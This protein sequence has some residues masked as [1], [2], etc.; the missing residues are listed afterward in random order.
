MAPTAR[1]AWGLPALVATCLYVRVSPLGMARTTAKTFSLKF[2]VSLIIQINY[3]TRTSVYQIA[4]RMRT[5]NLPAL[6]CSEKVS[7]RYIEAGSHHF[8]DETHLS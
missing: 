7:L 3:V 2:A 8:N 1:A 6:T 5:L 4:K